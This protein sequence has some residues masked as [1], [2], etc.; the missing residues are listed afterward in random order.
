MTNGARKITMSTPNAGDLPN[1]DPPPAANQPSDRP[2]PSLLLALRAIALVGTATV[3]VWN[4]MSS[5]RLEPRQDYSLIVLILAGLGVGAA[6]IVLL[7]AAARR[8]IRHPDLL[9]P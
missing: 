8:L 2:A 6:M 3:L 4:A 9:L 1:S 5:V 7:L